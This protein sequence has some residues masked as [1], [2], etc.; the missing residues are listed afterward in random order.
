MTLRYL[1]MAIAALALPTA[2][3]AAAPRPAQERP[4][5]LEAMLRCRTIADEHARLECFDREVAAFEAAAAARDVVIIDR[6]QV[7]ETKRSLFGLRLPRLA[8]FGGGGGGGGDHADRDDEELDQ[9]EGVVAS[10]TQTADNRWVI[11]LQDGATW[12][13]IDDQILGRRP[14]AGSKVLIKRAAMGSYM[15]RLDGQPGVR[16]R[17]EN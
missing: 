2:I 4:A 16:A 9:L 13:Q 1:P 11:R 12:R 17:R 8:I 14:R 5:A 7:R 6:K 3:S 10:A 15:M